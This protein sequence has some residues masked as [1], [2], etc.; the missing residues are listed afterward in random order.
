MNKVIQ[1]GEEVEGYNIRVLN[2]REIRAAAGILFF[3]V[4]NI[5]YQK[6]IIDPR[7]KAY[8]INYTN[9]NERPFYNKASLQQLC[10]PEKI[11]ADKANMLLVLNNWKKKQDKEKPVMVFIN[12]SFQFA[13]KSSYK[14]F[15]SGSTISTGFLPSKASLAEP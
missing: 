8:G 14:L 11:S 2:E 13:Y 1:F 15:C 4:L 5:L 12:V 3:A 9:V 10:T 7:N 6:Q